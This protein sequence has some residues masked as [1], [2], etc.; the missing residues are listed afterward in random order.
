MSNNG[1]KYQNDRALLWELDLKYLPKKGQLENTHKLFYEQLV[2]KPG[3]Q[4][5]SMACYV[6]VKANLQLVEVAK[7]CN[8][9][10]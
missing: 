1:F 4:D 2:C 7:A 3:I 9:L 6:V 8:W 5:F 10:R